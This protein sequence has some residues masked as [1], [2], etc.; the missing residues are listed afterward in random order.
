MKIGP[1]HRALF[2]SASVSSSNEPKTGKF[3][4]LCK[5]MGHRDFLAADAV[6]VR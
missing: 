5:V 4:V 6:T 3:R 2:R 1:N